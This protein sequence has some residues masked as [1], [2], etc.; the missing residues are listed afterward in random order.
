[1][2]RSIIIPGVLIIYLVVMGVIGWPQYA[3]E[4]NY[5][6]F[7]GITCATLIVI[8]L[9]FFVLKRRDKM[10]QESRKQKEASMRR[11]FRDDN[12]R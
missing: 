4:G 2:K 7:A 3:A 5:W 9:L 10:R 12:I 8:V 6:E 1:M 11:N